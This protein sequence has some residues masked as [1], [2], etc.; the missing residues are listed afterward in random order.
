[1]STQ[2]AQLIAYALQHLN[3]SWDDFIE[4]SLDGIADKKDIAYLQKKYE[5]KSREYRP[6]ER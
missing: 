1:M 2:E 6:S 5:G 4:S 3:S